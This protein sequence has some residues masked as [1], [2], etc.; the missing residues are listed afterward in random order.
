M[1]PGGVV[2]LGAGLG[3]LSGLLGAVLFGGRGAASRADLDALDLRELRVAESDLE[4]RGQIARRLL[5]LETSAAAAASAA[6]TP[7]VK[8]ALDI[9]TA[10]VAALR[11]AIRRDLA[12]AGERFALLEARVRE[13]E[14]ATGAAA[15]AS[16]APS[17]ADEAQWVNLARD[18]DPLRRFSALTQ[19]GRV[20]T[21]RSVR[22]SREALADTDERVAWQGLRNL[23]AFGERAA[24]SEIV[25]L[26]DHAAA[27]IRQQAFDTL[28]ALGAP[29]TDFIAVAPKE[30]RAAAVDALRR[31]AGEE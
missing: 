22:C 8:R 14:A 17:D 23:A 13:L 5:A 27:S 6:Q 20:R 25:P 11:D 24:A 1:K 10:D 29:K 3:L 28:R 4:A 21:D 2:A 9:V 7:D 18:P 12:A 30:D 31:W 16:G 15:A 26:L 19:L